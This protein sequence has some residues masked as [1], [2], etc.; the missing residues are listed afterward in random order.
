MIMADQ[1]HDGSHIKGL[2]INFLHHFWPSLLSLPGFLREFITPIVKAVKGKAAVS[3]FTLPEYHA[4]KAATLGNGNGGGAGASSS[5]AGGGGGGGGSKGWSIK[6][7]KGLGTSTSVEAKEYF[8]AIDRHQ[9]DFEMDDAAVT[10]KNSSEC[11]SK[12]ICMLVRLMRAIGDLSFVSIDTMHAH[13]S[14]EYT[15]RHRSLL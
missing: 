10:G 13:V 1:D 12:P 2:V 8:A 11:Q 4:W 14:V 7:Y 5:S 9:L 15:H 3:F 6:Y